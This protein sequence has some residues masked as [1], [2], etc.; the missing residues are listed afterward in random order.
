MLRLDQAEIVDETQFGIIRSPSP[1]SIIGDDKFMWD[2]CVE[3]GEEMRRPSTSSIN[4][5]IVSSEE[6]DNQVLV[7]QPENKHKE[8]GNQ[9]D[10][11][12][13]TL[14][15]QRSDD[16]AMVHHIPMV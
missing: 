16:Q 14:T 8:T 2:E 5:I 3:C 6:L 1:S 7:N 10:A 4:T 15:V 11:T 13:S 9:Q 12:S